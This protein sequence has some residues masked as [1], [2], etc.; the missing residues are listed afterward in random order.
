MIRSG[1]Y[2][3]AR[4]REYRTG[5]L[6][7]GSSSFA[8]LLRPEGRNAPFYGPDRTLFFIDLDRNDEIVQFWEERKT[9]ELI[10]AEQVSLAQPFRL[11]ERK[12]ELESLDPAGTRL[13][14]KPSSADTGVSPGFAAPPLEAKDLDGRSHRLQDLRGRVVLL[15]FWSVDC[16]WGDT[17]RPLI[18]A[19][20]EKFRGPDFAVLS[21]AREKDASVLREY[22]KAKPKSTT[23]LV[24][25]DNAWTTYNPQGMSPI[26]FVLD[27]D[28]VIRLIAPGARSQ[29]ALEAAITGLI[30]AR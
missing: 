26:C 20:A 23:V 13:V 12:F 25:D 22:L 28:G 14:L 15:E 16:P 18:N 5:T 24:R 17:V 29:K 21:L 8:V 30:A 10:P 1:S 3:Y 9:G 4:I 2:S 6:S 19:L 7:V 27:R 11:A